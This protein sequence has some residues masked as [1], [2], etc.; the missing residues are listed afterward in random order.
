MNFFKV[1]ESDFPLV[2]K[3]VKKIL[4]Q[5]YPFERIEVSKT[6]LMELFNYNKFKQRIIEKKITELGTVYRC[7]PL[8]DLCTGP[9]VKHTGVIKVLKLR[10]VRTSHF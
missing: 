3:Q 5:R 2:E 6:N 1:S 7:G 8:I 9:H 4:R 10:S